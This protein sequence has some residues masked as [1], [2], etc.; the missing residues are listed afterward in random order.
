MLYWIV[1][2]PVQAIFWVFFGFRAFGL[3]NVPTRGGAVLASNHQSFLDPMALGAGLFRRVGFVARTTL[4]K[5]PLFGALISSVGTMGIDR[6]GAD[7]GTIR[8]IGKILKA[9]RLL[10]IFPEGTRTRDGE[11]ARCKAGVAVTARAGGV[12][13]IPVAI[14]GSY[15]AWPRHRKLFHLFRPVRVMFGEPVRYERGMGKK[16]IEEDLRGRIA[17]ML[18]EM[19]E[20]YPLKR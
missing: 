11:V 1:R 12:P 5:N 15:E 13:I 8:K 10:V 20:K 7:V 4:F 9:G 18:Q 6:G 16:A 19:R 3:R 14:H 17:G 2:L